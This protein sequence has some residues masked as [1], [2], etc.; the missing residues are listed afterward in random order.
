MPNRD[1]VS[2]EHVSFEDDSGSLKDLNTLKKE[3]AV[4]IID[5]ITCENTASKL[6]Y[7]SFF[8]LGRYRNLYSERKED[9]LERRR[10]RKTPSRFC[11]VPDF[12]ARFGSACFRFT[13]SDFP[14]IC[15]HKYYVKLE[16]SDGKM[17]LGYDRW[18]EWHEG[19]RKVVLNR[20]WDKFAGVELREFESWNKETVE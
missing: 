8:L 4:H 9:I 6:L 7:D 16:W 15:L 10:R 1:Q 5:N 14:S 20:M 13:F 3:I 18:H 17:P 19:T 11:D 12:Y 2:R